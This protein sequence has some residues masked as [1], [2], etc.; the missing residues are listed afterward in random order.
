MPPDIAAIAANLD[1]GP[2]SAIM[3]AGTI[4]QSQAHPE[5]VTLVNDDPGQAMRQYFLQTC[6]GDYLAS[7]YAFQSLD[8]YTTAPNAIAL[9]LVQEILARSHLGNVCSTAPYEPCLADG[10]CESGGTCRRKHPAVPM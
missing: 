2:F 3:L 6:I 1:G 4:G 7:Q 10:E 9:P 5:I 8:T